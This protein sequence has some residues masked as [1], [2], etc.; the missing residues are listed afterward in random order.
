MNKRDIYKDDITKL[1]DGKSL[2]EVIESLTNLRNQ[3][4]G[5][6]IL[7]L[8]LSSNYSPIIGLYD[9]V[10]E[11]PSDVT[12]NR[13]PELTKEQTLRGTLVYVVPSKLNTNPI[14]SLA[15]L[16][17]NLFIDTSYYK[18]VFNMDVDAEDEIT[19]INNLKTYY[20]NS[21]N[22]V[23][24][25][26]GEGQA[27]AVGAG[28]IVGFTIINLDSITSDK[29]DISVFNPYYTKYLIGKQGTKARQLADEINKELGYERVKKIFFKEIK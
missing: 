21:R 18:E 29:L 24:V 16:P 27:D 2:D 26:Y 17:L 3:N 7:K 6:E 10:T 19:I 5:C 22:R 9:R 12:I 25:R 15:N 20:K 4:Y 14:F 13:N 1:I 23:F 8:K 28:C 11:I